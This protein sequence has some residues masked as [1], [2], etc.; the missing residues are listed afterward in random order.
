MASKTLNVFGSDSILVSD[1]RFS[2]GVSPVKCPDP[3]F[4]YLFRLKR[5]AVKETFE[6]F[7]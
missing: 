4:I 1:C 2:F 3:E 7:V 5:P 6:L